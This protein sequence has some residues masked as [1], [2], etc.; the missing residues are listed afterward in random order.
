MHGK[1][2]YDLGD[3]LYPNQAK[4]LSRRY[5]LKHASGEDVQRLVRDADRAVKDCVILALPD[6]HYSF[7]DGTSLSIWTSC[8][9]SHNFG[10]D[11]PGFSQISFLHTVSQPH[12]TA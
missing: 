8:S 9:W 7:V 4:F 2:G 6:P 10:R 5:W 11:R 3:K 12:A 1:A